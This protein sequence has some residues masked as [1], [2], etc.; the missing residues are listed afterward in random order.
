MAKKFLKLPFIN[1]G[2]SSKAWI[3]IR[4]LAAY[5][6]MGETALRNKVLYSDAA[7]FRTIRPRTDELIKAAKRAA[8]RGKPHTQYFDLDFALA[9]CFA[10]SHKPARVMRDQVI[11]ILNTLFH[12]GFVSIKNYHLEADVRRAITAHVC[13]VDHYLD[14][15]TDRWDIYDQ[16]RGTG[17]SPAEVTL[18][19]LCIPDYYMDRGEI[20]KVKAIDLAL[21]LI[22]THCY[23]EEDSYDSALEQLLGIIGVQLEAGTVTQEQQSNLSTWVQKNHTSK[24]TTIGATD[25]QTS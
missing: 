15:V 4:D 5:L 25:E 7:P 10:M 18:E 21:H 2:S 14:I 13:G 22:L 16:C 6:E 12:D 23:R 19:K 9:A 3:K 8:F 1:V 20:T 11:Y 17:L 24:L